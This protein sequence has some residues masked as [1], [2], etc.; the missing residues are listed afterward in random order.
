MITDN[1]S[2]N[3]RYIL[4]LISFL[5]TSCS[6][7]TAL[8]QTENLRPLL[9]KAKAQAFSGRPSDAITTYKLVLSKDADNAEAFAG[10]G[11]VNYQM[12]KIKEAI[13]Y[14]KKAIALDPQSAEPHYY[15]AAI[16]MSQKQYQSATNEQTIAVQLA[17]LRPCNC[18]YISELSK[19]API[20]H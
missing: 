9:V 3:L 6:H 18:G 5:A 8:A 7:L 2:V 19:V 4:F 16:Y 13:A 15:L 11:W 17:K 20:D 12:H 14:E 10:L 1:V